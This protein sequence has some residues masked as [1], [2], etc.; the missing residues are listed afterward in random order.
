M[1]PTSHKSKPNQTLGTTGFLGTSNDP[2]PPART[3]AADSARDA[4]LLESLLLAAPQALDVF[5][6]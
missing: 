3:R 5:S 2:T 6:E 4:P 1:T